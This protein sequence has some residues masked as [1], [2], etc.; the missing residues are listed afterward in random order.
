MVIW[1]LIYGNMSVLSCCVNAEKSTYIKGCEPAKWKTKR[2]VKA[3]VKRHFSTL[4]FG[5]MLSH[6]LLFSIISLPNQS[7]VLSLWKRKANRAKFVR[8]YC[9]NL[10]LTNPRY[11]SDLPS[12][13]TSSMRT[14]DT[15]FRF[16]FTFVRFT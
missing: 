12:P 16:T 4:D 15:L 7:T 13:A 6:F 10:A 2:K 8:L 1:L 9:T 5:F 11:P 14:T 3:R